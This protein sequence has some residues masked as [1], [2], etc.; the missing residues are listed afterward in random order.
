M[1]PRQVLDSPN[2]PTLAHFLRGRAHEVMLRATSLV[3]QITW[4]YH[5]MPDEYDGL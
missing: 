2:P 4:G 1:M 5:V 3:L